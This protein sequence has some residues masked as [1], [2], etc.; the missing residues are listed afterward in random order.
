[1]SLPLGLLRKVEAHLGDFLSHKPI[2]NETL[3]NSFSRSSSSGSMAT[4]E[5]LFEQLEPLASSRS[6]MEKIL[7]RRN[8]QLREQQQ[9]W[10][11]HFFLPVFFSIAHA[12]T[13]KCFQ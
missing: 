12:M 3:G 11:V 10:Q 1:M 13:S 4:D 8:L 2:V 7:A 5:G 9:A 6:V